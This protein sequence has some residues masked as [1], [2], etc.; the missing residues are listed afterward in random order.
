MDL[1]KLQNR[2]DTELLREIASGDTPHCLD[3]YLLMQ[4]KGLKERELADCEPGKGWQVTD[5]GRK[6]LNIPR[7]GDS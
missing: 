4:A 7:R 3:G 6:L 5:Q 2:S 1:E